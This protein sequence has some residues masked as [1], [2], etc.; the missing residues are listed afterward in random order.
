VVE[1]VAAGLP[2]ASEKVVD[3]PY[4]SR[5]TRRVVEPFVVL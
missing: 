4:L 2:F 3:N 1:F 5:G